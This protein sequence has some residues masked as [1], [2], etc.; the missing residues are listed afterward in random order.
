M[1]WTNPR[2]CQDLFVFSIP[3]RPHAELEGPG[4]LVSQPSP[5]T[6]METEAWCPQTPAGKWGLLPSCPVPLLLFR[7]ALQ[8]KYSLS[9]SSSVFPNVFI[10]ICINDSI[11]LKIL[12]FR[13]PHS[14]DIRYY[15]FSTCNSEHSYDFRA[16]HQLICCVWFIQPWLERVIYSHTF[17]NS[18]TSF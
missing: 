12:T 15:P 14:T 2:L 1:E 8:R 18:L 10:S 13:R 6:D 3:E 11:K 7:S 9:L 5:V 17:G 4:R 16:C